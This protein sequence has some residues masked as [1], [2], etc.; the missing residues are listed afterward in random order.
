ME[1][2]PSCSQRLIL[3]HRSLATNKLIDSSMV[4]CT[5]KR[6]H[7]SLSYSKAYRRIYNKTVH[8]IDQ[9]KLCDL[10]SYL[11]AFI[12]SFWIATCAIYSCRKT[13]STVLKKHPRGLIRESNHRL[14]SLFGFGWFFEWEGGR[15]PLNSTWPWSNVKPSI[16]VLWGVCWMFIS[17]VVP[18]LRYRVFTYQPGYTSHQHPSQQPGGNLPYYAT[19]RPAGTQKIPSFRVVPCVIAPFILIRTYQTDLRSFVHLNI[20]VSRSL[21]TSRVFTTMTMTLPRVFFLES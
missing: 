6:Y 11:N 9:D 4:A 2:A 19:A 8:G 20:W 16:L 5:P 12:C 13:G 17:S 7:S 18:N 14:R 1:L 21:W 3:M 10:T 15:H